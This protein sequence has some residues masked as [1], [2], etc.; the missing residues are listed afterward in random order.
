MMTGSLTW[1]W[2][3]LLS[4]CASG[5]GAW[6]TSGFIAL[7]GAI[8]IWQFLR[9]SSRVQSA[10]EKFAASLSEVKD[11]SDFQSRFETIDQ[12]LREVEEVSHEWGEYVE[13]LIFP[14][15]LGPIQASA[16]AEDFFNFDRV[17][18]G[19]INLRSYGAV[20]GLLTG[21]G[22]WGTFLGL[23]AGIGLMAPKLLN[24]GQASSASVLSDLS[25]LL[26]GAS[27]AF[28]TSLA[29]LGCSLVFTVV[30]RR[31]LHHLDQA[32]TRI[33][34]GLDRLTRRVSVEQIAA[35]QL[36]VMRR[37][38]VQLERFNTDLALSI[39][40]ALDGELSNS[41]GP[42]I[43]R[44]ADALDTMTGQQTT[45][46][47]DILERLVGEFR[48]ALTGAAGDS[49]Q[50]MGRTFAGLN[51]AL[52]RAA[53]TMEESTKGLRHASAAIAETLETKLKDLLEGLNS[54]ATLASEGMLERT[55]KAAEVMADSMTSAGGKTAESMEVISR[56]LE[57]SVDGVEAVLHSAGD[58]LA[59]FDKASTAINAVL[60]KVE[61]AQLAIAMAADP[62]R[63]SAMD[64]A[65]SSDA[66]GGGLSAVQAV[67]GDLRETSQG[68][69]KAQEEMREA[70]QSYTTRFHNV[71]QALAQT[72]NG[73]Q[74]GTKAQLAL[75]TTF[76]R[77]VDS[78]FEKALTQLA[79]A[80]SE[81]NEGVEDLQDAMKGRRG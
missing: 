58:L 11:E 53:V 7:F 35:Q 30:E 73:L 54:Q 55:R 34:T 47:Q 66:L 59:G 49:M 68:V 16:H 1:V 25:Q 31:K 3:G 71:D 40:R 28:L 27:T 50:D 79:G 24:L 70:W 19:L 80:V 65:R 26:G 78:S 56:R 45:V 63:R 48:Q 2:Y 75:M 76:L 46:Q 23:I 74:D 57:Q 5:V 77:G 67:A 17:I 10:V 4:W 32:V 12:D 64:L 15:E 38:T 29:G 21:L 37:Q 14:E 62:V 33:A 69:Q 18:G 61:D 51:G 6:T 8:R 81:M 42:L 9:D 39:A 60:G 44:M 43:R 52:E 20:P 22:I 13:T 36:L 41:L 72:V